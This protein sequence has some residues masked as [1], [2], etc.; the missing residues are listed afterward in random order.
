MGGAL[1]SESDNLQTKLS[2]RWAD[3]S[4]LWLGYPGRGSGSGQPDS[5]SQSP[6]LT[7]DRWVVGTRKQSVGMSERG[8]VLTEVSSA[9]PDL[10]LQQPGSVQGPLRAKVVRPKWSDLSARE[11]YQRKHEVWICGLVY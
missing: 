9:M 6:E 11:D 3:V 4:D 10:Q 8:R 7:C 5:P 2:R 1:Y